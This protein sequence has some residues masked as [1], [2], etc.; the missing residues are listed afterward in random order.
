MHRVAKQISQSNLLKTSSIYGFPS[1]WNSLESVPV[2]QTFT[3]IHHHR[4]S[5]LKDSYENILVERRFAEK[6]SEKETGNGSKAGVGLIILHR[7]RALNALCDA[8]FDDLVHAATALNNEPDIGCLVITGCNKAFA[9]GADIE[10]MSQRQFDFA[11]KTNM[12][13]QW[14]EITKISKPIIAAVNGY[15]LGGGCE[16]AMMC[17]IILA[18]DS[19]I[20][21]QPEINLGVI[22]GA[23][24]TQRLVR[25]VGKSKAMEMVLTGNM[26]DAERAERD[27][28]V[29]KVVPAENLIDE[30]TKMGLRI[31]SKGQISIMMAKEAVNAADEMT[32]NEG[33]KFERRLFHSLFAT[34][35]QKEGMSAFLNKRK[36]EF[37]HS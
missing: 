18:G 17:D 7:P 15:A 21:G 25:A 16:L 10:E 14:N 33:L 27:G 28:L 3:F 5:T 12:F 34:K 36:P 37:T 26:I 20:F 19:A 1:M 9:A 22:P 24:G 35:D 8:L 4:F 6:S 32:L 30:A 31:A 29:S 13:S 23:G 11:Y 2:P